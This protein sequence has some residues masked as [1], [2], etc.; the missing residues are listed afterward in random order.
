MDKKNVTIADIAQDLGISKTTVSRSI[1]GKGRIGDATRERVLQYIAE[2][3]YKPN[4]IAKSLAN[5]CTYNIG[6]IMPE[7]YCMTDAAFFVN[8]LFGVHAAAAAR[9]YDVLLTVCDNIDLENLERTVARRKVDG[10]VVMR[11]F[12]EDHAIPLLIKKQMPFVV[13][14]SSTIHS[15]IQ[16]DHKNEEACRKLTELLLS[17]N[18]ERIALIGSNMHEIVSQK[19]YQG[20]LAA[21]ATMGRQVHQELVYT[22]STDTGAVGEAVENI[23]KKGADGVIC[24]DDHICLET[25]GYL[26]KADCS[27]PDQIKVAS[28]FDSPLLENYVPSITTIAFDVYKLGWV[29][30]N[31][32]ID[33]IEKKEVCCQTLVDYQIMR[34]DS[35]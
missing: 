32:L 13:A 16:I 15:V 7:N 5:S 4:M 19:R 33:V 25:L 18:L 11:T 20:F 12:V 10:V 6:V 22:D 8:C 14:G 30:G 27:I 9:G 2:H 28:F 34:R 31:T 21:H 1:S 35:V 29:S 3:D 26:K 23:L 24:M 17:Q